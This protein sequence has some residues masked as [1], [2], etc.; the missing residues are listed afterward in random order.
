MSPVSTFLSK[1]GK[2]ALIAGKVLVGSFLGSVRKDVPISPEMSADTL[3]AIFQKVVESEISGQ[4]LG[5]TGAQKR[6][7]AA[8]IIEQILLRSPI[9]RGK[10][11]RDPEKFRADVEVLTGACADIWNDFEDDAVETRDA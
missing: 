6:Q 11:L 3:L 4:R 7:A 5:L 1:L 9:A 10:K 2:G 8:I